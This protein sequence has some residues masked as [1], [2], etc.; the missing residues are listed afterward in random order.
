MA[1]GH[2]IGKK[3]QAIARLVLNSS[4]CFCHLAMPLLS[5]FGRLSMAE[6]STRLSMPTLGGSGFKIAARSCQVTGAIMHS[7]EKWQGTLQETAP[8]IPVFMGH[9][10]GL[11]F[12]FSLLQASTGSGHRPIFRRLPSPR[13]LLQQ[14][15]FIL[16]GFL[17][18]GLLA[19]LQ[20]I[21]ASSTAR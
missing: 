2:L 13:K 21:K 11:V 6:T 17:L 16:K 3:H 12:G 4:S 10:I 7:H 8:H 9:G 20:S 19:A 18:P 14:T 5:H 1:V 15:T